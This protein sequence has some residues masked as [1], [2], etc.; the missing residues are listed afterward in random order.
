SYSVKQGDCISS[1][2]FK[3]GFR[4][5]TVWNHSEN[6]ELKNLRKDPNVLAPGDSVF[7]PDTEVV[8]VSAATD[9]KHRFRRKAVPEI[10]RIVLEDSQGRPRAGVNYTIDV[11]GTST[12]DQTGDDGLIEFPIQPDASECNIYIEP[13]VEEVAEGE[14]KMALMLDDGSGY[15]FV[16]LGSGE[17]EE[18]PEDT[19]EAETEHYSF[20]LGGLDPVDTDDGFKQR[21]TNLGYDTTDLEEATKQFQAQAGI[22]SSGVNDPDTKRELRDS[23]HDEG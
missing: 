13:E 10:L 15:E 11:D 1:I 18:G 4:P 17:E 9:Q 7:I 5:D 21:L 12:D 16:E 8:Q 23:H 14:G 20:E 2:A 3:S 22:E 19:N 6:A